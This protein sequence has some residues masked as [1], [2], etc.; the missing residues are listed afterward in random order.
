MELRQL[1][2]F[3]EVGRLGSFSL[4]SKSL[5]ITQ[6]TI[7]Q[8]IRKL[9]EELGV[10]LLT[11]DTRHV[12]FSDY[13][14]Q[15]YPCAV[16]VLE[17]A[18]AGAE[19]IRDVKDLKVG[20]LSVGATYSFGPLLKQTVLDYYRLYPHI[21]LD[22]LITSKEDLQQKLLDRELDVALT[23]KSPLGE[24]HI[25][26]HLL[27]RSRLCL[28]G[29]I[30]ELKGV[31]KTVS[32]QDLTRFP[33]ALPSKGLQARDTL[34]DVLFAQNVNLD[35]RLEINSVR[36]LLDLVGSSPLVTILSEEA[37]HQ[38]TGFE[39]VPIDHPDGRM[40]G[41]YHYLKGAYHKMAAQK[42]VE[43]LRE[44]NSFHRIGVQ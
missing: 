32:V 18:K 5:F 16:Q 11:R 33:L 40:D 13:G 42:F 31:G 2:Y 38:V 27:F 6:S 23:Y 21:R 29:R 22:L 37:I 14:E 36:T 19:R 35:I 39:A 34:E 10:E 15:F 17:E 43:L 30:G 26:S 8:Q 28:V 3:V 12:T 25:E 1:K 20:R 41:C 24:D 4:A 44:N 9:E 7:S